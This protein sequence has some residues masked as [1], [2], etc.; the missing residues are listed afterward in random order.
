[1]V[2]SMPDLRLFAFCSLELALR[3]LTSEDLPKNRYRHKVYPLAY[4]SY[5]VCLF[6]QAKGTRRPSVLFDNAL[7]AFLVCAKDSGRGC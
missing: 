3:V 2:A 5:G 1:M 4:F 7:R 6:F